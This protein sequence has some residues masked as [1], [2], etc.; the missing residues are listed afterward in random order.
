LTIFDAKSS[1]CACKS[2]GSAR[3][4]SNYS[5]PGLKLQRAGIDAASDELLL[6]R[7][8]AK[9]DTLREERNRLRGEQGSPVRGKS[10]AAGDGDQHDQSID[11]APHRNQG[12]RT[13]AS[14]Q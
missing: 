10:S 3:T 13:A 1:A 14:E 5:G 7:M 4:S 6:G 12:N 9:I 8:L 2:E 11:A